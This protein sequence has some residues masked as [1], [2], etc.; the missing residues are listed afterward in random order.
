MAMAAEPKAGA[1][2]ADRARCPRR[3]SNGSGAHGRP[4][5]QG[6]LSKQ[7]PH[8]GPGKGVGEGPG[9]RLVTIGF[10]GGLGP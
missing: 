10:D 2:R 6:S 9:L 8:C 3:L 1:R 4:P 7:A 5:R